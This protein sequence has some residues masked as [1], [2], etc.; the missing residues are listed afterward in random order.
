MSFDQLKTIL[1]AEKQRARELD[2]ERPSSCPICGEPLEAN[3]KGVLNCPA[4]HYRVS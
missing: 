4:G 3:S 1:D 2:I